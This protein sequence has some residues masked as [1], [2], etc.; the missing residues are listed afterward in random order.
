MTTLI[1]MG[2]VL[3]C[4]WQCYRISTLEGRIFIMDGFMSWEQRKDVKEFYNE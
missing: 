3:V 1:I 2:L 4:G